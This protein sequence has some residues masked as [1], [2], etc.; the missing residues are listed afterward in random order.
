MAAVDP[1]ANPRARLQRRLNY[2]FADADLLDRALT[3]RSL[4]TAANYERLEF[5][6]DAVLGASIASELFR[7]FPGASE[8]E[9]TWARVQLVREESLA[10][11]AREIDLAGA[12]R[13]GSSA[14]SS[15]GG[16]QKSILADAFEALIGAIHVE[17]GFEAAHAVIVALFTSRLAD[18]QLIRRERDPKTR[19][20]ELT[21]A[22]VQCLPDY[23]LVAESG[24][25]HA[26]SFEVV[27]R[28]P[29]LA[30]ETRASGR[31]K[32]KAEQ[33]AAAAMIARL[34]GGACA[35][36]TESP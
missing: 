27:C 24:K 7:R 3:H 6:G 5:L 35:S 21:Q 19:L 9:L 2:V 28:V 10:D 20:Q 34:D 13:V 31:S 22:R 4:E 8:S 14:R 33:A 23:E 17:S 29:G 16:N 11:L 18:P 1:T 30:V 26:R 25:P 36:A 32:R 12:L 15:G